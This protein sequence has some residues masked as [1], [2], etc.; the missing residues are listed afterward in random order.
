MFDTE[1]IQ[2]DDDPVYLGP[3]RA[4]TM[5]Q[6]VRVDREQIAEVIHQDFGGV[7]RRIG[8]PVYRR[9]YG[10]DIERIP[11]PRGFRVPNFTTFS[12]DG[13]QSTVEHIGRFI[14]QCV[15]YGGRGD[16]L[17]KLFPSSLTGVAFS[18]YINLPANL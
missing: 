15:E 8:R 4:D 12:G 10:D 18:W 3:R 1:G 16:L 14:V 6:T 13:D 9:P 2:E 17:L 7:L 11:L 5:Q